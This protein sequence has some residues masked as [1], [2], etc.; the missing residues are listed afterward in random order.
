MADDARWMG[1][2]I[3]LARQGLG[4]VEPNP[5][6]G[7]LLIRDGRVIGQGFHRRFGD[8]HAEVEALNDAK[9]RAEDAQG[10]TAYV[11]LEPCC[12]HG[13][14]P[15]CAEA[16][17]A[18]R[19]ARV[20]VA[21]TDPFPAVSGGGIER[22]REAGI[23]VDVGIG[24]T[25]ATS[26]LAPY[27][28]RVRSGRPWVIAKWAMSIDG[29]IATASGESQ[30]ITGEAA[31]AAVHQLRAR[32]D[33]IGVGAGTVY[34]D[35][36][37]LT[38]RLPQGE[39][40]P[41]RAMRVVYAR[42]RLPRET[43]QLVQTSREVP[44]VVLGAAT[45]EMEHRKRLEELGVRVVACES[46]DPVEIIHQ[47]LDVMGK[48]EYPFDLPLTNLML[49]GGQELLGN[50]ALANEIDECHVFVGARLIGGSRAP[51]PMGDFR[52]RRILDAWNLKRENVE[53][54]GDDVRIVYQR[55]P[56]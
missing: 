52:I 21:V 54:F 39:V 33:A 49:E 4:H 30:W 15:P 1:E 42:H 29:K 10:A 40:P 18:A 48:G 16:L 43:H 47:S 5:P 24:A 53:V 25:K 36:P 9:T 11:T 8:S 6:V 37:L 23:R 44:T 45:R 14:T 20:V 41:R 3:A 38:A 34:A 31:R 27:L 2:A 32:V 56:A 26:L 50:F 35:D 7:C 55:E 13:K 28:K 17:V 12:H 46:E 19:V 51:G 22:L